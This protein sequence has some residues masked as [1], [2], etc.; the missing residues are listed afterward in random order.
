MM[1]EDGCKETRI[2]V[3]AIQVL[4]EE[5]PR[6]VHDSTARKQKYAFCDVAVQRTYPGAKRPS[7]RLESWMQLSR[8]M[9]ERENGKA[10]D[11][12]LGKYQASRPLHAVPHRR[13]SGNRLEARRH[14]GA[15]VDEPMIFPALRFAP[16]KSSPT[17][18]AHGW[19]PDSRRT[20]RRRN[21]GDNALRCQLLAPYPQARVDE[22]PQGDNK[23]STRRPSGGAAGCR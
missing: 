18:L 15:V 19:L 4:D 8:V 10:G 3:P 11:G 6:K 12:D 5:A 23:P 7:L 14:V 13:Q 21:K 22:Q 2:D 16:S 1:C 20:L 17:R 9:Q